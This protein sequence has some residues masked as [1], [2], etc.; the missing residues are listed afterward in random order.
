[1]PHIFVSYCREDADF[2]QILEGKIGESGFTTWRDL[3]LN[4]GDD[5]RAEIDEGIKD[6]LAVVVVMSP[7]SRNSPYVN[8]EWSFAMGSGVPVVPVLLKLSIADLHP[9]LGMLQWLDFSNYLA[10]PWEKLAESLRVLAD[11]Q[12]Q[13]TLRVPKDAPPVVREAASALDDMDANRR[14]AAIASLG[15]MNHPAAIELLAE[16]T[17]HPSRRSA[18]ARPIDWGRRFTMPGRSPH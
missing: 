9:R 8:Y 16:A 11:A 6:A 17:R 7:N 15:Q 5:W 10:R 14:R 1:M 18:S 4:A 12:R 13:F 2:A 3:N